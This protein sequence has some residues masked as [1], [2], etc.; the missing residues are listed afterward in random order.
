MKVGNIFSRIPKLLSDES[1]EELISSQ[2][3]KIERII[4]SGHSTP[5]CK[6]YDQNKNEFIIVLKGNAE[7]LF[8]ENNKVVKMCEGDYVNIPA[9]V[10][11]KVQKT[12]SQKETIWLAIFY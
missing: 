12:D 8:E 4:S 7:L 1:F 9:H 3:C 5:K 2:N 11:H 10:K 6:W